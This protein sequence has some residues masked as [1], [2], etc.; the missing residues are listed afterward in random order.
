M[1]KVILGIGNTL[2]RDEGLGVHAL[3]RIDKLL[4]K[5]SG[6]EIIDGGTLGLN[7][8]Q[9]VEECSHLL[10]LDTIDAGRE[11]GTFIELK[12]EEIPLFRDVKLSEHQ[13]TFQEVLGLAK[14]RGNLPGNLCLLGFQPVDITLGVGL[15]DT[16]EKEMPQLTKRAEEIIAHWKDSKELDI[17][18]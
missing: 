17:E 10:I 16:I 13:I 11:P 8:L 9:L 15:S 6:V 5:E 4:L 3:E 14:I 18:I 12:N 7:L 1:R 2:N